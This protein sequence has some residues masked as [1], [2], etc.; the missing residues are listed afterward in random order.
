MGL[1]KTSI[2]DDWAAK[3]NAY[4][5]NLIGQ[6]PSQS[7]GGG[8]NPMEMSAEQQMA[9]GQAGQAYSK[10]FEDAT[11]QWMA[12]LPP[13][14][15][16]QAYEAFKARDADFDRSFKIG[17]GLALTGIG[18]IAGGA[19]L[20]AL[21]GTGGI[22]ATA[23]GAAPVSGVEAGLGYGGYGGAGGTVAG[24]S[25]ILGGTALASGA[26]PLGALGVDA[27]TAA[28]NIGNPF[29]MGG[30][31]GAST[32]G[33]G[34]KGVA[35]FLGTG[36]GALDW[37]KLGLGIYGATRPG[38]D[39]PD[40]AK[41]AQ[42]QGDQNSYA[43][44]LSAALNRLNE[45]TPYGSVKYSSTANPNTPGGFDYSR[46]ITLSPEQ[47][48]L[49]NLD[50]QNSIRSQQVA[51]G[52]Q[53]RVAQSMQNPFAL[54]NYGQAGTVSGNGPE[55]RDLGTAANYEGG[56]DAVSK[57]LY[58]RELALLQP[59]MDRDLAAQDTQ[60]RNQGLMPGTQAYDTALQQLRQQQGQNL[61]DLASRA[62]LAGGAEQSRLAGLDLSLD[63]QRFAQGQTGFEN[64]L[65]GTG[66]N[67]QVRDTNIQQ[68]L[69]ERQQPLAEFN[70]FRTGNQPTLP[71]F[72]PY[73]MSQV[74]PTNTYGA[75]KDQ[76]GAAVNDYNL[77]SGQWQSL[78]NLGTRVGG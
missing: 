35:D 2:G 12:S 53:D 10:K 9:I 11:A 72:Q 62:T 60:L 69:L 66:F 17:K 70:A 25:G 33:T 42:Q 46:D 77:K 4:V 57:A 63:Q 61:N 30:T 20:S 37:A 50:S 23:G 24:Q 40:Y 7:M 29:S 32:I 49:Y 26:T 55:A 19:A 41:L 28:G 78:L 56:R 43:A 38:P 51:G 5:T 6:D 45:T 64:I 59:Q 8:Q 67:N 75:A 73:A 16:Q 22:S 47:Q 48:Q 39:A 52:M 74:Q 76:Y 18:A 65:N 44:Q 1:F 15:A 71:N 14:Q 36:A 21:G 68:G 13:E 54:S 31:S 3:R 58:D 27:A 34:A